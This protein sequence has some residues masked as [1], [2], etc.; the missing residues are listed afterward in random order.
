MIDGKTN[1]IIFQRCILDIGLIN[2]GLTYIL[3]GKAFFMPLEGFFSPFFFICVGQGDPRRFLF[4]KMFGT[5]TGILFRILFP[6]FG[7]TCQ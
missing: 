3:H 7:I 5:Y 6:N 2:T 1:S 4:L